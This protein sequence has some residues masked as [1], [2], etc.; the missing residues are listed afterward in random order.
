MKKHLLALAVAGAIAAPAMAQ[1]VSVYGILD[2]AVTVDDTGAATANNYTGLSGN[3]LSSSRLGF[4][5]SEDLGGGMKAEV[6]LESNAGDNTAAATGT[7]IATARAAYVG[8]S[9]SFGSIKL[10][11]TDLNTTNIDDLVSQWGNFSAAPTDSINAEAGMTVDALGNDPMN[12]IVY[13]TPNINGF[14]VEIGSSRSNSGAVSAADLMGVRID[15]ANGPLK[16]AIGQ[17]VQDGAGVA[18]AKLTQVGVSYDAGVASFGLVSG[19]SN[20]TGSDLNMTWNILSV[21]M[22]L[23]NGLNV[24]GYVGRYN[25]RD[26]ST[27]AGGSSSVGVIATKDLS[28][29]TT[30]YA[31]GASVSNGVSAGT[32]VR[33]TNLTGAVA[34]GNDP[35]SYFVGI[36]H[37]F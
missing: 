30:V 31:G 11:T 32:S 28:K 7:A 34:A 20:D 33:A 35:S 24:G 10:G 14:T 16:A 21:K 17:T 15:Y 1:N 9:G 27:T 6:V 26:A 18:Q 23:G 29:R 36:R 4:K 5:T 3:I 25:D 2:Q 13:T 37:S 19:K 12:A 22:P 8:I